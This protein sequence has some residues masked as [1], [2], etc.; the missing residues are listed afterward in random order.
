[1]VSNGRAFR[2]AHLRTGSASRLAT[3]FTPSHVTKQ[4]GGHSTALKVVRVVYKAIFGPKQFRETSVSAIVEVR[5]ACL[6]LVLALADSSVLATCVGE[7]H[8]PNH[9]S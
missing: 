9:P 3:T 2:H 7:L 8:G 5:H 6:S 4:H 1:M